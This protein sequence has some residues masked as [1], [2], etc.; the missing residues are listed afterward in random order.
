MNQ[1]QSAALHYISQCISQDFIH[2]T[3]EMLFLLS[4]MSRLTLADMNILLYRCDAEERENGKGCY[5]IPSWLPLK[6][7]GLQGTKIH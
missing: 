7:G 1:C 2:A 5:N 4:I 6:Y 3:S